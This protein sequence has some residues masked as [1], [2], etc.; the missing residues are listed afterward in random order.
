MATDA[1][2]QFFDE[3]KERFRQLVRE[4]VAE[5]LEPLRDV[6]LKPA[7]ETSPPRVTELLGV[8]E[9]ARLLGEDVST[10][11]ARRRA[12]Q[13]VYDLA[14]RNLIPSVRASPRRVRFDLSA[15]RR[16][17]RI[18]ESVLKLLQGHL[19][20]DALAASGGR[21]LPTAR[22]RLRV[23][24]GHALPAAQPPP[25]THGAG[26]GGRET[27]QDALPLLPASHVR[28]VGLWDENVRVGG[29]SLKGCCIRVAPRENGR[30]EEGPYLAD[31]ADGQGRNRTAD[32]AI[33][34]L[35]SVVLLSQP[36]RGRARVYVLP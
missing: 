23:G 27:R 3:F 1:L 20:A 4:T 17:L 16:A 25:A 36:E 31:S 26:A 11:R 24:H 29:S 34:S 7:G 10:D 2:E 18:S 28:H 32:T 22:S 13:K 33:F 6:L 14:R 9:V 30:S 8:T 5:E 15:V 12:A 35:N 19:R 21:A